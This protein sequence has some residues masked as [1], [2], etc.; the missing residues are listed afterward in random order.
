M[1]VKDW[2]VKDFADFQWKIEDSDTQA[3][4]FI[5]WCFEQKCAGINNGKDILNEWRERKKEYRSY[6]GTTIL[7]YQHYSRHDDTHSVNILN[8]IELVLGRGRVKDLSASD[9]WLLLEPAYYHDIGMTMTHEELKALWRN[10]DF[11]LFLIKAMNGN[12][13]DQKQAASY[14][15]QIDSLINSSDYEKDYKRRHDKIDFDDGWPADFQRYMIILTSEYNRK[16]H[17]KKAKEIMER[18]L[19]KKELLQETSAIDK[20]LSF[21][22]AEISAMHNADYEEINSSLRYKAKGFGTDSL[23]PRFA[24]AMLRLG[25]LLDMD[26]NRFDIRAIEHFGKLPNL[27]QT[28]YEKHKAITHFSICKEQISAEAFSDSEEVCQ[29]TSKWFQMLTSEVMNLICDWNEIMPLKLQGCILK[30]CDLKVYYKNRLYNMNIQKNYEVDKKRLV[31]L[32]T[33]F[34]I[35]DIELDCIREYIQ[36]ALDASKMKLWMNVKNGITKCSKNHEA[37]ID[38]TPFELPMEAYELLEIEIEMAVHDRILTLTITDH[39]VGMEEE[40]L[41]GL[42]VIGRSWKNREMY[43]AEEHEMPKWMRPTGG[44]GIG[45]QSAFM[46][47][48]CVKVTTKSEQEPMGHELTLTSPGK[49]GSVTICDKKVYSGG[50]TIEFDV[51]LEKFLRMIRRTEKIGLKIHDN[52]DL[53]FTEI[54]KDCFEKK[55][56][57]QYIIQYLKYYIATT[58]PNIIFPIKIH[59][60]KRKPEYYKSLYAAGKGFG[61]YHDKEDTWVQEGDCDCIVSPDLTVRIWDKKEHTYACFMSWPFSFLKRNEHRQEYLERLNAF[62]YRNARVK[63]LGEHDQDFHFYDFFVGCIDI[64]GR[65]MKDV[66]SIQ[67][68]SFKQNFSAIAYYRKYAAVYIKAVFHVIKNLGDDDIQKNLHLFLYTLVAIQLVEKEVALDILDRFKSSYALTPSYIQ[69]KRIENKK[70][71]NDQ[72][73]VSEVLNRLYRVIG[74]ERENG[75]IIGKESHAVFVVA[76]ED[77]SDHLIKKIPVTKLTE[78]SDSGIIPDNSDNCIIQNLRSSGVIYTNPDIC[79]TL[80]Q[81]G[82]RFRKDYFRLTGDRDEKLLIYAMITGMDEDWNYYP[83]K[84]MTKE[85]FLKKAFNGKCERFVG[86]NISCEAYNSLRVDSIPGMQTVYSYDERKNRYL[87]SPI[88][89]QTYMRILRKIDIDEQDVTENKITMERIISKNEFVQQVT[90]EQD[91]QFLI[92]WVCS[93]Q[94]DYST[95]PFEQDMIDKQYRKMIEDIYSENLQESSAESED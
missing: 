37:L 51:P 32:M 29:E 27:S 21:L 24:A 70:L 53:H 39:G 22:V 73:E 4:T 25:D 80:L 7:D 49:G 76:E 43:L 63:K 26:N 3:D 55:D 90:Q 58:F 57:E 92:S 94:A 45:L 82:K 87:V 15:K 41:S 74:K 42:S 14:F 1:I 66:I 78:D 31:N 30:K 72:M 20:R 93:H 65:K 2:E 36:N 44:Y 81:A 28:H 95:K 89:R 84:Y 86:K 48:E 50:T 54:M 71:V 40:C 68:N 6:I 56:L 64:M 33:G 17:A 16:K 91:Y 38:V 83:Q 59:G 88:G 60:D 35:Y 85:D 62:C 52:L 19:N 79:R 46:L 23:H 8:A 34:N 9:L 61:G 13:I 69:I 5:E 47:T 77:V 11:K 18:L 12:D 10:E 75:G 67:R